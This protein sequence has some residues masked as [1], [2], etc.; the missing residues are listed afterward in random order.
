MALGGIKDSRPGKIV[1]CE[2]KDSQPDKMVLGEIRNNQ[3]GETVL[4][5]TDGGHKKTGHWTGM[6]SHD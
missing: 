6:A 1:L 4:V 3:S 5:A 2:I